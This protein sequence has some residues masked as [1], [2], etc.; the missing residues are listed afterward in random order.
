[1]PFDRIFVII[2]LQEM[3]NYETDT[4][5]A[6]GSMPTPAPT[7]APTP[8]APMPTGIAWSSPVARAGMALAVLVLLGTIGASGYFYKQLSDIKKDPNKV[9]A[10]ETNATIS[11][12]GKL[13]VLPTG[14]Q[15]T[16]AT[17]TD[18]SKLADQPFFASAKAGYKV[19]IYPNAKKAILYDPVQNKI[20]EVSP[21]NIGSATDANGTVS[22][23]SAT[24]S[25]PAPADTTK[26]K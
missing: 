6:G 5:P 20:V 14:E 8:G 12:I 11:A 19:L 26:K 16:L 2:W 3:A 21:I 18:P 9:A 13:I 15:P 1:L 25:T 23:T 4:P 10:D 22:G 17:V 7:P 24:S